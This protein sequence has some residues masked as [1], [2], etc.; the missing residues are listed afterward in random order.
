MPQRSPSAP[1]RL[2]AFALKFTMKMLL[3]SL[4]LLLIPVQSQPGAAGHWEGNIAIPGTPLQIVIDL[5]RGKEGF[6][7]GT[8]QCP[9][10]EGRIYPCSI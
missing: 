3:L 1:L 2:R 6:W 8:L 9:A 5:A 7:R 4:A 10:R